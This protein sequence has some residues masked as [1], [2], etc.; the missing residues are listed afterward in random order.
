MK[1][2]VKIILLVAFMFAITN[3]QDDAQYKNEPG[4]VDF[5]SLISF[6]KG[7]DVTEVFLDSQLLKM[8]SKMSGKDE[9]EM[10]NLLTGLKLVRVYSFEVPQESRT[11]LKD[12]IGDVDKKLIDKNWIRIIKVKEKEEY[13]NVYIKSAN[14]GDNVVGLAVISLDDGG[15]ASFVNIVGQINMDNLGRLSDKFN[16]PMMFKNHKKK[17]IEEKKVLKEKK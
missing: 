6:H 5:S 15:E 7:D 16:I 12:R 10:K 1:A 11:N 2:L 17:V 9:P 8:M 14:N 4:Y 13:T 3:A